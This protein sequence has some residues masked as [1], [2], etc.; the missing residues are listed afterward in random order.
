M[1]RKCK[2]LNI[3]K[4][5]ILILYKKGT[6]ISIRQL[7]LMYILKISATR[8]TKISFENIIKSIK[9]KNENV[10]YSILQKYINYQ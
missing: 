4:K 7:T 1:A 3:R 2:H 8:T 9:H 5:F 6:D 10:K